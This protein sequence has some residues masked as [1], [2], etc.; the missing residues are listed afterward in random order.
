MAGAGGPQLHAAVLGQHVG[1]VRLLLEAGADANAPNGKGLSALMLG[2]C[3]NV[4][5]VILTLLLEHGADP[6]AV[7]P[8]HGF[9]AVDFAR[10]FGSSK[11]RHNTVLLEAAREAALSARGELRAQATRPGYH[12]CPIC[13]SEVRLVPRMAFYETISNSTPNTNPYVEAFRLSPVFRLV[14]EEVIYHKLAD[15]RHLRKEVSESWGVLT[16]LQALQ[17]QL[18]LDPQRTTVVDLCSG[19]GLTSLIVGTLQPA[20]TVLAVDRISAHMVPHF[21]GNISYLR[22]DIMKAAFLDELQRRIAS[23][24]EVVVVGMH[25]CGLLSL[26]AVQCLLALPQARAVILAPC[27]LPG[28]RFSCAEFQEFNHGSELERY[29]AWADWL[30]QDL[31]NRGCTATVE[32]DTAILSNRN[33]VVTAFKPRVIVPAVATFTVDTPPRLVGGCEIALGAMPS[34]AQR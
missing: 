5:P 33:V 20:T 24:Q 11:H 13:A 21:G 10:K 22:A 8:R 9:A 28:G 12:R 4:L 19:S 17:V 29:R 32:E 16:R 23:D 1:V 3:A 31:V 15:I 34:G 6:M 27:C 30:G 7:D 14:K 25:L 2:A 26:R 18:Q